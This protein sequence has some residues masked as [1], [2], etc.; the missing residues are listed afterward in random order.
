M[1][2]I[3]EQCRVRLKFR[4]GFLEGKTREQVAEAMTWLRDCES[5]L[6]AEADKTEV[7]TLPDGTTISLI[8]KPDGQ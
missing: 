7:R 3:G 2:M 5:V 1:T 8:R 6:Q 4:P